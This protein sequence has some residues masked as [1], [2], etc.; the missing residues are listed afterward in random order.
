MREFVYFTLVDIMKDLI[1][2]DQISVILRFF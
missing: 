1:L 2:L